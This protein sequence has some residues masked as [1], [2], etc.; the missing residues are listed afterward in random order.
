MRGVD[1]AGVSSAFTRG[2][3]LIV[4]EF[5]LALLPEVDQ[6]RLRSRLLKVKATAEPFT[7]SQWLLSRDRCCNTD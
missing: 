4:A 5:D 1:R 3:G 7:V 2:R 6:R